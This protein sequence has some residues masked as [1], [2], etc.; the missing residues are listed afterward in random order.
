MLVSVVIPFYKELTLINR[1]VES[2]FKQST[3]SC[4]NVHFEAIVGNDGPYDNEEI[5]Q[6]IGARYRRSTRVVKNTGSKGPGGARNAGL[7]E[8]KGE[9]IAFLDADDYW[10]ADKIAL[11]LPHIEKGETF[12]ATGY[13]FEDLPV[14]ICP[15]RRIAKR[16]DIFTCLGI[17]TS[18]VLVTHALSENRYF[19]ALRFA[20]DI[21]YWF[22]LA[23]SPLFR[24]GSVPAPCV[25]YS[26][27]GSTRNKFQQLAAFY[28]V[29]SLNC[30]PRVE[31]L[32]ILLRY[33]LRGISNHYLRRKSASRLTEEK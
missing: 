28:R 11:Q 3:A 1:A 33:S 8:A 31:R 15:P 6:V 17:G 2:V 10:C 19:R 26:R 22:Q 4:Q 16:N 9:I 23:S 7:R 12:V 13:R 29:L 20:Q 24:Y 14:D 21:D 30:I 18:T 25:V 5:L 32:A 27:S